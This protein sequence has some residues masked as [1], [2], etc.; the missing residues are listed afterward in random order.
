MAPLDNLLDDVLV[1]LFAVSEV[2]A[3]AG[4]AVV[5]DTL[6]EELVLLA[7]SET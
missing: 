2:A 6:D 3:D 5:C 7:K 1:G 4:F